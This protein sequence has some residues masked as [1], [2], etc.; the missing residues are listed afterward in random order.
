MS[1]EVD[2]DRDALVT[3]LERRSEARA[4]LWNATRGMDLSLD[5][6]FELNY[7]MTQGSFDEIVEVLKHIR[8]P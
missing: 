3:E 4:A 1:A 8:Q 2:W 6:I 5:A 7:L